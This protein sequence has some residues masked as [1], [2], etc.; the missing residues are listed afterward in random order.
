VLGFQYRPPH[1]K[2]L[3]ELRDDIRRGGWYWHETLGA[4]AARYRGPML[5]RGARIDREGPLR[6]AT[7]PS[8]VRSALRIPAGRRGV[9]FEVTTTLLRLPG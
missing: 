4:G 3:V 6:F 1:P 7:G 8:R 9:R 5:V 2:G